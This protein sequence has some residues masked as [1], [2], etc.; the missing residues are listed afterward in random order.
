MV[1]SDLGDVEAAQTLEKA[2]G[3]DS[4]AALRTL[5]WLVAVCSTSGP[6]YETHRARRVLA[7]AVSRTPPDPISPED[8]PLLERER[9]LARIP[10]AQALSELISEVPELEIVRLR[11]RIGSCTS[12]L[13]NQCRGMPRR[14]SSRY[15]AEHHWIGGTSFQASGSGSPIPVAGSLVSNYPAAL[16]TRTRNLALWARARRCAAAVSLGR[17]ADVAR[18]ALKW[19][20]R[21]WGQLPE[22]NADTRRDRLLTDMQS[23][24]NHPVRPPLRRGS[25]RLS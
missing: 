9:E 13:W 18:V 2:V 21:P 5:E 25:I 23:R 12:V 14:H 16:I 4:E 20:K 15:V 3:V 17:S 7:A 6:S 1:R 8:A 11:A 19:A 10:Q 22:Q 24:A